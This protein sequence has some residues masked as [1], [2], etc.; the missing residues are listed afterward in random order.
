MDK[1]WNI[2]QRKEIHFFLQMIFLHHLK[3][4]NNHGDSSSDLDGIENTPR[5]PAILP[6][7][8]CNLKKLFNFGVRP[9]IFAELHNLY[10]QWF[11]FSSMNSIKDKTT[12]MDQSEIK[13]YNCTK[14]QSPLTRFHGQLE[15]CL[16][17][18]VSKI[19]EVNKIITTFFF[20]QPS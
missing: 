14:L 8:G 2:P 17:L 5:L 16:R 1:L 6:R 3:Y 19:I 18:C 12:A 10:K 15:F 13:E 20:L 11:L 7:F 4:P 9:F